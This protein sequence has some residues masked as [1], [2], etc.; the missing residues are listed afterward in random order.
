MTTSTVTS[1][2]A[3]LLSYGSRSQSLKWVVRTGFLLED[4]EEKLSPCLFWLLETTT[5]LDS[6]LP[7][8]HHSELYFHHHFPYTDSES[9]VSLFNL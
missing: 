5:L 8:V 1:N 9:P 6:W 4:P 3:N 7:S 2:N